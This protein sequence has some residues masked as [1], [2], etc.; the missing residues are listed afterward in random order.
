LATP[1]ARPFWAEIYVRVHIQAK[2][3]LIDDLRHV[4]GP[5]WTAPQKPIYTLNLILII[6]DREAGT[7]KESYLYRTARYQLVNEIA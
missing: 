5:P 6:D 7:T 1:I 3:E 4:T 2:S